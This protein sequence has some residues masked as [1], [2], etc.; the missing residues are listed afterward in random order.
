LRILFVTPG[1]FSAGEAITAVHAA[2]RLAA[3][4]AEPYFLASRF[5][6]TFAAKAFGARVTPM[7]EDPGENQAAFARL[8]EELR[9]D[10]IVFADFAMA[11]FSSGVAPLGDDAWARALDGIDAE[12]F[13]F[14]HLGFA[15]GPM[16]VFYGPPHLGIA[17]PIRQPPP[18]MHV[19]LPCPVQAPEPPKGRRGVPFRYW[20]GTAL[21][22]D[23]RARVRAKYGGKDLLVFHSV[24]TWAH[25]WARRFGHPY[26]DVLS[27]LVVHY[28]SDLGRHVAVVSV[29]DG[30]LLRPVESEGLSIRNLSTLPKEDY[31]ALILS[32]DLMLTE[33]KIS[34]SLG[35]AVCGQVPGA[36]LRNSRFAADLAAI[37]PGLRAI[38][39]AMEARLSGAV[40]PYEVFPI[41]GKRQVEKLGVFE[42]SSYPDGVAS[43]EIFGG[44]ETKR[45]LRELL[46]DD[47]ARSRIQA[48]QKAYTDRVAAL[49]DIDEVLRAIIGR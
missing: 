44:D 10:G 6:G 48:K 24:P 21:A 2:D 20:M 37:D 41:W 43:L 30:T 35:K 1:E 46:V 29:N 8:L 38:V 25:E 22:G 13:T 49:P 18:R 42:G 3:T 12:L 17:E 23:A 16:T 14:D 40:Y 26:Y 36:V 39:E 33:N 28:L 4:G 19:L 32:A 11:F 5:T 45:S 27:D 15:R 7:T 34:V 31:E 9:P 47:Q